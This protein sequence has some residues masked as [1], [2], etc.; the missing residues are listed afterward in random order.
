[1][2]TLLIPHGAKKRIA[3][4]AGVSQN[5][6]SS[7]FTGKHQPTRNREKAIDAIKSVL[8]IF[9]DFMGISENVAT[10]SSATSNASSVSAPS[11]PISSDRREGYE[12]GVGL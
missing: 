6:V 12:G 10:P 11:A 8:G 9:P 5:T 7:W 3:L 2:K 1:M 4:A